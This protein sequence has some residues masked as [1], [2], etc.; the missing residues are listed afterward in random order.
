MKKTTRKLLLS[1]AVLLAGVGVASAQGMHEGAGGGASGGGAAA[2]ISSGGGQTGA[3]AQSG[4]QH[5]GRASGRTVGQAQSH[6]NTPGA[7]PSAQRLEHG[8][9]N[10][11]EG[12]HHRTV[13]QATNEENAQQAERGRMNGGARH[14]MNERGRHGTVGQA[15]QENAPGNAQHNAQTQHQG[16]TPNR[17][18]TGQATNERQGRANVEN[19]PNVGERNQ[20]GANV[21]SNGGNGVQLSSQQRSH[22]RD[23]VLSRSNVPRVSH[24]DFA[25]R[26]GATVPE[27][28][29]FARISEFPELVDVFPAYRSDD[30]FV[31]EDQIVILSPQRRIVEVIPLSASTH[32][33][34]V[35]SRR[36]GGVE[37]SSTEI[38]EI[39]RVLVERGYD[40]QVDG[41]WSPS[42]RE[43]LITF[44]RRQG[45]PATGVINTQTVASLGLRGRIAENHIQGAG[46]TVG[47]S[48]E[49]EGRQMNREGGQ[50]NAQQGRDRFENQNANVPRNG[51]STVGRANDHE[52]GQMGPE[53]GQRNAQ[54]GRDRFENQNA[55][56]P[57]NNRSTVGQSNDHEPR[58]QP[59]NGQ[60]GGEH[61][62]TTGGQ[63]NPRSHATVGQSG[64][65]SG[66]SAGEQPSG[67]AAPGGGG[68]GQGNNP[69]RQ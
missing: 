41:V 33:G 35:S 67:T 39:Q 58:N 29:H 69:R 6:D 61:Q 53:R 51:K 68:M 3:G 32:V 27:S 47:M 20:V 19:Q 36:G 52:S 9:G 57:R 43:A 40:V 1:T 14:D 24:V 34:A 45:L 17:M 13:G 49:R 30:F 44:Q 65:Q 15:Q 63:A 22:I 28:V 42:T 59:M 37:L 7:A 12:Q 5:E 56:A 60:R 8:N 50:L 16:R 23:T 25:L 10:A 26:A 11:Q 4:A 62:S 48:N 31:S 2:G 66:A 46:S 38:R 55:N 64:G 18:T 54:Q 21:Q